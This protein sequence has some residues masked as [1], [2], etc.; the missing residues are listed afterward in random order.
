MVVGL[1]VA[2]VAGCGEGPVSRVDLES[3]LAV[4]FDHLYGMQQQRMGRPAAHDAGAGATCDKGGPTVA[5][6]GTG[7]DWACLV[8]FV[9][10][11]GAPHQVT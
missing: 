5:D 11:D 7:E 9:S 3:A 4:T 1:L 2:P 6:E 8:S 10:G